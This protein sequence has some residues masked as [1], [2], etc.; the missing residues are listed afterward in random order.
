MQNTELTDP[1]RRISFQYLTN[2]HP[3]REYASPFPNGEGAIEVWQRIHRGELS[4]SELN[5]ALSGIRAI[6]A[7]AAKPKKVGDSQWTAFQEFITSGREHAFLEYIRLFEW[8]VKAPN[9]TQMPERI[10]DELVRTGRAP[11]RRASLSLYYRLFV[12]VIRRLS[13]QGLKIL[14]PGALGTVCSQS[15]MEP[16]DE[17]LLGAVKSLI[18]S[19]DDRLRVLEQK[20][21]ENQQFLERIEDRPGLAG[22]AI[23]SPGSRGLRRPERQPGCSTLGG[24]GC[25]KARLS[26]QNRRIVK[27]EG[28]VRP[29]RPNIIGKNPIC[30]SPDRGTK[31]KDFLD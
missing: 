2:S 20:T 4:G 5:A 19:V 9:S 27:R 29:K 7:G 14:T 22:P 13:E 31:Q 15:S 26:Q 17:L 18:G 11:S 25:E 12:F 28:L 30:D 23:W 3:G 21:T 8:I 16:G 1:E 10:M 6:L 24:T